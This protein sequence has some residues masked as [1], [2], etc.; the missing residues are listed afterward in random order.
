MIEGNDFFPMKLIIHTLSS[1]AV[2]QILQLK[3][4]ANLLL[5]ASTQLMRWTWYVKQYR[6]LTFQTINSF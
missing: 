5:T 4:N 3:W 6:V 2:F 1:R